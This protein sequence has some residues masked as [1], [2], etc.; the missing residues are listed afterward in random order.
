MNLLTCLC[1][2][3]IM[4]L[5]APFA[6]KEKRYMNYLIY[7]YILAVSMGVMGIFFNPQNT[8]VIAGYVMM[9]ACY[10][11]VCGFLGLAPISCIYACISLS[12]PGIQ[13][14]IR[15]LILKRHV[16][17]ILFYFVMEFYLILSQLIMYTRY[18][19]NS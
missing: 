11:C 10:L 4:M 6:S 12:K 1:Y 15:S 3:L 5:R 16:I 13:P 19:Q 17:T 2:D 7:S 14:Q 8:T 9:G 18:Y